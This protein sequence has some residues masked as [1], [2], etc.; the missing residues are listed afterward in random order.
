MFKFNYRIRWGTEQIGI[1]C[2]QGY[3]FIVALARCPLAGLVVRNNFAGL[4]GSDLSNGH[5]AGKKL[6]GYPFNYAFAA[7]I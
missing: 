2:L 7:L 6:G 5:C 1:N 4:S 3:L